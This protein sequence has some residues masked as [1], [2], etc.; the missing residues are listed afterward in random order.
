MADNYSDTSAFA[1]AADD[2][3]YLAQS[4]VANFDPDPARHGGFTQA[5]LK[6]IWDKAGEANAFNK[7]GSATWDDMVAG[8]RAPNA[9]W[10]IDGD[11]NREN[12]FYVTSDGTNYDWMPILRHGWNAA[13]AQLMLPILGAAGAAATGIGAAGS[14][15]VGAEG[16]SGMDLAADAAMGSGNNIFTAAGQFGGGAAGGLSGMDLAADAGA[17]SGN[18]LYEAAGGFGGGGAAAGGAGS[19]GSGAEA[20]WNPEG[21]TGGTPSLAGGGFGGAGNMGTSTGFLGMGTGDWLQLGGSLLNGYLGSKAANNAADAQIAATRE[22]NALLKYM[23]DT[24]RTDNLPALQA[25]NNGLSGYQNLLKNP[26]AITSDPGYKFGLDQGTN[27]INSQAAAKGGYYSGATLKALNKFG[28][29]YGGTKLDQSLN[30]YGN[31]AG[32][33]QVGSQTIANA[34][35]QYAQGASNN[36]IGAGNARGAASLA[37]SNAWQNALNGFLGYQQYKNMF[38]G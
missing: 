7:D 14:A 6:A 27:A 30:R 31:L 12:D 35:N 37:S 21:Y 2:P 34:G 24:T 15:G 18:N 29:D 8:G 28:Q 3:R 36:L 10:Y 20:G 38:G 11:S 17:G 13:T 25:R 1:Y 4:A 26:S 5:Q 32:L 22:G 9:R 23:Y 33:G 19:G 16:L